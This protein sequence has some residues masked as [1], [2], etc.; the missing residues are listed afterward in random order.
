MGILEQGPLGINAAGAV[1]SGGRALAAS[2]DPMTYPRPSLESR[3]ALTLALA[4]LVAACASPPEGPRP[5]RPLRPDSLEQNGWDRDCDL[6][7]VE[8][9][10]EL[11]FEARAVR[12]R[13]KNELRGLRPSTSSVALHAVGLEIDLIE[14]SRGRPLSWTL[15]EPE[16]LID[17]AEPL[18]RGASEVIEIHYSATPVRGLYFRETSKDAGGPA[19][20]VWSQ[21]QAEDNRHWIPTWDYP[22]ERAT[23]AGSFRVAAGYTALSNGELLGETEHEDGSSTFTWRLSQRIPTYLIALAAGRWESYRDEWRGL[24]VE[25]WVGPGTGEAKA[26]RAFGETPDMLE[27]FSELLGVDYPYTKYAQVAVSDFVAGGMENASLT[28]QHDYVLTEAAEFPLLDGEV[29]LLVAHELAHQWFGNLVTCFGWSHLWLNEAWASYLELLYER[30]VTGADTFGLWL[31]RYRADYLER[32]PRTRL[33]LSEDWRAQLS[34]TRCHHEYVKGP[35]VLFMLERELGSEVFWSGVRAYLRRHADG[36]VQT[37]D[38]ARAFFDDSG[39][40]VE[41]FLE[42]WVEGGGHPEYEVRLEASRGELL[43]EVRQVQET[44]ELVPLFDVSVQCEVHDGRGCTRVPLRVRAARETFRLPLVGEL[45]DFVFDAPC[46]VLCELELDKPLDMW[47]RQVRAAYAPL[48]WRAVDVLAGAAQAGDARAQAALRLVARGDPEVLLRRR[49]LS[50][51][52][53]RRHLAFLLERV[54]AEPDPLA[55]HEILEEL[56]TRHLAP[57]VVAGLEELFADAGTERAL[58]ALGALRARL[59]PSEAGR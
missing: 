24:P 2:P 18:A 53:H 25:Y 54:E 39:R 58:R 13:V 21:G 15:D 34:Q 3:A 57:E 52:G 55:R 17:L 56:A 8:L 5:L 29:R 30:H 14:D 12:G 11:D 20:Q 31:E 7:H 51:L 44:S 16:L 28:L 50:Q 48:R 10:L 37:S 42:Q 43:V 45:E 27:Y 23:Y 41:G 59:E 35:W 9:D 40:N 36:L 6:V 46:Q 33:P 4:L 19:P 38:F 1:A 22:N 32:G 47:L 26:R 49:A